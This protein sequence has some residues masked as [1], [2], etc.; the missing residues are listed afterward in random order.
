LEKSISGAV[1]VDAQ[2]IKKYYCPI[3]CI[4]FFGGKKEK[5]CHFMENAHSLFSKII[6]FMVCN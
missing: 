5:K 2:K 1:V 3:S 4:N 6:I